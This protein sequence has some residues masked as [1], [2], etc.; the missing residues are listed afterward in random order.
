MES[1]KDVL[2]LRMTT[3]LLL[4]HNTACALH[5][6]NIGTWIKKSDEYQDE[7]NGSSCL[8]W[9]HGIPRAEKTILFSYATEDIKQYWKILGC[10]DIICSYYYYYIKQAQD[11]VSHF[12]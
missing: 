8:F 6:S 4:N 2:K 9:L 7:K 1:R 10:T 3:D 11:K 12:F 5:N